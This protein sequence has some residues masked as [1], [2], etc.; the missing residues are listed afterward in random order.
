MTLILHYLCILLSEG[1]AILELILESISKTREERGNDCKQ[2]VPE[3]SSFPRGY[4]LPD[5]GI[6]DYM[7]LKD[8][9][10]LEEKLCP[11]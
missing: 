5:E 9:Y 7:K 1:H 3:V 6:V 11:T 2:Y 10:S 8:A 4:F